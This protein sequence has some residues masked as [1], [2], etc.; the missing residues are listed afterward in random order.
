[1]EFPIAIHKDSGSVYGVTVPDVPG[2]HSAGETI[3]DAIRNAREAITSH[4]EVLLSLE[5]KIEAR[6]TPIATLSARAEFAGAVWALA[7]VDMEKLDATAE[8][9]N[10]SLPR[11]VLHKIDMFV[12]ARHET[13]SG[14]L[15]RAAMETMSSKG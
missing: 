4:F 10:I 13:R 9:I 15:A 1:M 8:R 11:F 6:P 2:C 12:G 7:D 3:E 14:F 5:E